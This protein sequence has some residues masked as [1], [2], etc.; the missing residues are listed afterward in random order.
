MASPLYIHK[1]YNR[2]KSFQNPFSNR[3]QVINDESNLS[4][5][6][7]FIIGSGRSGNTLLRSILSGNSDISIPPESYRIPFAIKKF[8]IFNNRDWEDIVSQVLKEFEDCKEFYTWE[9]DITDA[10]KRLE[11][12]ADSKRTL[13]NIFDELFCTYTEKHSPGSKIWGDKTPMNTLYL[14]WIGTVFPR[15][16][17]IHI[18]RDGRD[19]ASSYLKMERYDTILEAANRWINSIESAQSF[20]SKIKENYIEI[21]YEELVTKPEEVI[22][23][24]C[25]F[26]DID[27]DSKMLDHTKQVKKLGDTD[28]EHHSNLSKPISS[29]SVGKWRNNLSESDQE[30]ITKL[31]HKHLQRLGYAD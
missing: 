20:G 27:Y 7:F 14:D 30:S 29:D 31:L 15:S 25:D 8:H 5:I 17:F 3:Y 9:I 19:V 26:L 16:K 2:L 22:K 18:I 28:K 23:D 24:T 4:C 11:N 6:P 13:S 21:R 10:Q 1:I 12:I